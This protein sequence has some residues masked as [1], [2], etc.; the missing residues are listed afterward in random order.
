MEQ[1]C[2]E[3]CRNACGIELVDEIAVFRSIEDVHGMRGIVYGSFPKVVPNGPAAEP[4]P[5]KDE[6]K[7]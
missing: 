7:L 1:G 4:A 6:D 5:S 2:T 3:C